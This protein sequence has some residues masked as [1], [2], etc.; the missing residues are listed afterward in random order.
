MRVSTGSRKLKIPT[1]RKI[2]VLIAG[3]ELTCSVPHEPIQLRLTDDIS[4]ISEGKNRAIDRVPI[5][6]ARA[7]EERE[8]VI[9][10]IESTTAFCEGKASHDCTEHMSS[11]NEQESRVYVKSEELFSTRSQ[12][13]TCYNRQAL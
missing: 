13:S 7:A 6:F 4:A 2:D 10:W 5:V 1:I 12:R 11:L 8:T 3:S 9:P